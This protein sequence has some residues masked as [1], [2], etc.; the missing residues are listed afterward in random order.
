MT[1]THLTTGIVCLLAFGQGC[2]WW[3]PP[4]EDDDAGDPDLLELCGNGAIDEDEECDD[5]NL[6]NG[7]GCSEFCTHEACTWNTDN[8]SFPIH[9]WT[10]QAVY[11]E[12]VFDGNC[13][14]I[15]G[16]GEELPYVEAL[17]RVDKD[18]GS[19][20]VVVEIEQLHPD[21]LYIAG[22]THRVSDN[23]VYFAVGA[24]DGPDILYAVDDQNV[25]DEILVLENPVYSLTVAPEQFEGFA[26][27]LIAVAY[28]PQRLLAIDVD[29]LVVTPLVEAD[30]LPSV[31]AF[32]DDGTLYVVE[33]TADRISTV[34]PDGVIT[35]F[36]TGL[37]SPSGLALSP[38]G[39]RM[40]VAHQPAGGRIDQI[41]LSDMTLTPGVPVEIGG[42]PMG[43][44]VDGANHVLYEMPFDDYSYAGI[45]MFA[46]P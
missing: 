27:Q 43:I 3:W 2:P 16:G 39:T 24:A 46:A 12:I 36:Y 34:T 14:L 4:G 41:S 45:G 37:D 44:V 38:D 30:L 21:S 13:D 8:L 18:D 28:S 35:P 22:M 33:R 42:T 29:T 15:V 25:L 31:V 6:D 11:G 7:D 23:R 17:Y 32:G 10:G 19:V 40:F 20:S 9:V 1:T 5:Q 26:G